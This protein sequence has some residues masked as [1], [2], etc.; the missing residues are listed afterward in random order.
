MKWP[1]TS[2][3]SE[4]ADEIDGTRAQSTEY[5][6]SKEAK[7]ENLIVTLVLGFSFIYFLF[8]LYSWF[9]HPLG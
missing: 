3:K 2:R 9:A 8:L 6:A 7:N 5:K 1:S 4:D